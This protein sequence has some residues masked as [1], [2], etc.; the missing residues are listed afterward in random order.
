MDN[1]QEVRTRRLAEWAENEELDITFY[2]E[3]LSE[4]DRMILSFLKVSPVE[5]RKEWAMLV[6]K[7]GWTA[8]EFARALDACRYDLGRVEDYLDDF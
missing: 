4:S 3:P 5:A 8:T 6:R 7:C 1:E 2:T